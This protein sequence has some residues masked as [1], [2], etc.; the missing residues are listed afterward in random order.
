M[1]LPSSPLKEKWGKG[2][3]EFLFRIRIRLTLKML[4]PG[5]NAR[6]K[7]TYIVA[8]PL[9]YTSKSDRLSRRA[10]ILSG[11]LSPYPCA[12]YGRKNKKI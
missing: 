7:C 4:R 2:K 3:P 1:V 10:Q 8:S 9:H 12:P 11:G 6:R 5:H